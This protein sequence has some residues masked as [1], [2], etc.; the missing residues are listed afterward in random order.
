VSIVLVAGDDVLGVG[1]AGNQADRGVRHGRD[2]SQRVGCS[3]F[4]HCDLPRAAVRKTDAKKGREVD[5]SSCNPPPSLSPTGWGWPCPSCRSGVE[6][7]SSILT[8]RASVFRMTFVQANYLVG[9]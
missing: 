4:D 2:I 7:A 5:P 1:D 3:I 6:W 9:F 8:L